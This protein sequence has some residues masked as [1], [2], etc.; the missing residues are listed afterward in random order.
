GQGSCARSVASVP[1]RS[2]VEVREGAGRGRPRGIDTL[3][4]RARWAVPELVEQRLQRLS[5]TRG[6]GPHRAGRL[7]RHPTHEAE[8]ARGANDEVPEPDALDATVHDRLETVGRGHATQPSTRAST[9]S[10]GL[11]LP[12]SRSPAVSSR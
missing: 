5:R 6:G 7:I 12:P 8:P 2:Y 11:T 3:H 9:T 4:Q 1:S 10:S